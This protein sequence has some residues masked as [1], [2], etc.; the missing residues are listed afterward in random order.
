MLDVTKMCEEAM[1]NLVNGNMHRVNI[2]I[3]EVPYVEV[4][5]DK[6]SDGYVAKL[7]G[8]DTSVIR[9]SDDLTFINNFLA[10]I[11]VTPKSDVE[12]ILKRGG[13]YVVNAERPKGL[14]FSD[15]KAAW[16]DC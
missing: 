7:S 11:G 3:N 5:V 6:V 4:S 2:V 14:L 16:E 9:G 12:S 15:V 10:A 13:D 1:G 8:I